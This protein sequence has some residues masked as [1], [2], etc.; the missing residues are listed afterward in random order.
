MC[1][2]EDLGDQRLDAWNSCLLA[3]LHSQKSRVADASQWHENQILDLMRSCLFHLFQNEHNIHCPLLYWGLYARVTVHL[4]NAKEGPGLSECE[5]LHKDFQI[6]S[7]I[8]AFLPVWMAPQQY[9]QPNWVGPFYPLNL[10]TWRHFS[11]QPTR[12]HQHLHLLPPSGF[13]ISI[14]SWP[15]SADGVSLPEQEL[16]KTESSLHGM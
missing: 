3:T 2:A 15:H 11:F 10:R 16:T 4:D 13:C 12:E 1:Q 6:I 9:N 8:L 5:Q 7:E 14:C